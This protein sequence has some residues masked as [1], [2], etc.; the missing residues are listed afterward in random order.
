MIHCVYR[1]CLNSAPSKNKARPPYFSKEAC[2]TNFVRSI[3]YRDDVR[4]AIF[5]D[6]VNSPGES[7][8][9]IHW[10]AQLIDQY[11]LDVDQISSPLNGGTEANSFR[12]VL[13]YTHI[14][15]DYA[16]DIDHAEEDII[17]FVEDDY[18]HAMGWPDIMMEG[19][20]IPG[21]DYVTLY[22]HNDKYFLPEYNNLQS[23][24]YRTPSVHWRSTPSTTNTF[25]AKIGTML[26]DKEIHK[27]FSRPEISISQDHFKFCT[28]QQTYNR[29][30]I[31]C[32]PGYST[33]M[34]PDYMSPTVPWELVQELS[35]EPT[36]IVDTP[37]IQPS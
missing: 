33:H 7:I 10:L 36:N 6:S 31:S 26:E 23:K 28:L 24:I 21:I 37:N 27:H 13:D 8:D 12:Y 35:F 4:L 30:L 22:D 1:L 5:L 2:L 29:K 18:L 9:N 20:S 25:A 3:Q 32:I 14:A 15:Y 11:D 16:W 34:E 17:Y 19:F